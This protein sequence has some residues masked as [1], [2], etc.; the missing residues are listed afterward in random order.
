MNLASLSAKRQ[1]ILWAK[2]KGSLEKSDLLNLCQ[3]TQHHGYCFMI[4]SIWD[5]CSNLPAKQNWGRDQLG[6]VGEQDSI[7]WDDQRN[8]RSH[9][10]VNSHSAHQ[11]NKPFLSHLQTKNTWEDRSLRTGNTTNSWYDSVSPASEDQYPRLILTFSYHSSQC[12]SQS[13][14]NLSLNFNIKIH[15]LKSWDQCH[16]LGLI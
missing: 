2:W 5:W 11:C 15:T 1:W 10:K 7:F 13:I 4:L 16:Y 8:Q 12:H 9:R 3:R 14:L 6:S